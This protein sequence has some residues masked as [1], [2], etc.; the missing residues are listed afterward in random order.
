MVRHSAFLMFLRSATYDDEATMTR[1]HCVTTL[2]EEIVS[3]LAPD[4]RRVGTLDARTVRYEI[5]DRSVRLRS[6]ILGR[7]ALRRLLRDVHRA[8]KVEYLKRDLLRCAIHSIEYRY[9]RRRP[10]NRALPAR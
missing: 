10:R 3:V 8:V 7:E 1:E 4:I 9:P 6:I 2:A 5:D